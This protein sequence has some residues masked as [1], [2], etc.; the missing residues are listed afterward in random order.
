MVQGVG[1]RPFIHKLAKECEVSGRIQNTVSGVLIEA[2]GFQ[3]ALEVF[4]R[5]IRERAPKLSVIVS[6]EKEDIPI[7]PEE[8]EFYIEKSEAGE[9]NQTL[10]SPDI[11]ICED[12]RR[13]LLDPNDRRFGY[14]FLNCT[15][16]GPR[17]SIIR[18][19]P[20]DR[21][22][23]TMMDFEMCE[24]CR[25]EYEDIEDRRYH[26]QPNCCETCGPGLI[27]EDQ[28]GCTITEDVIAEAKKRILSGEILAIKGLG[29]F[30]LACLPERA[31]ELRKRKHRDEKPFALMCRNEEIVK[32]LAT[33]TP[34]EELVLNGFRKP[35]V[36]L[37]KKA[38]GPL[39]LHEISENEYVGVMLPYTPLHVLLMEPE[40]DC[41]IMTS[42]NVSDCPI[43]YRNEEAKE[44]LVN[45][46]DGFVMHDREIETRC[47]DSLVWV[48]DGQ[49]YFVRRSRGYAPFPIYQKRPMSPILALGAEQKASFAYAKDCRV[50]L[51]QHIGDLKNVETLLHY[52][53]QMAHFERLFDIK[54]EAVVCDLHPDYL[55]TEVANRM[56]Q[57]RR[58]PKISV[59]HHHAHMV[60][61][62]ADNDVEEVCIGIVWDGTGLGEPKEGAPGAAS[63]PIWGGE[64]LLG[65]ADHYERH[66]TIRPIGLVGG[67]V[68]TKEIWRIG[69]ALA[70]DADVEKRFEG[71]EAKQSILEKMLTTG[72]NVTYATS[73]GRLFDGIYTILS[74][75]NMVSY[76]GQGAV[77]LEASALKDCEERYS[78]EIIREEDIWVFDYREMVRSIVSECEQGEDPGRMAAKFMNTLVWMAVD[79]CDRIRHKTGVK[80]VVLSGGV[81]QNQY[82]LSKMKDK[83]LEQGFY[84]YTHKRVSTNDEGLSL[85][86]LMIAEKRLNHVSGGAF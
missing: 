47:D 58:I 50:F 25:A 32:Q 12:C 62:M 41:L 27:F 3:D 35:I 5:G 15:N 78:Y 30:H 21:G 23:T 9:G 8:A 6:V 73:M 29:G 46:A 81:F 67:D 36:L 10:I 51:S 79:L 86:Q 72:R 84:V 55:S 19:V 40:I 1:F 53:E 56:S 80:R 4:E 16:C 38:D 57:E 64:V 31:N 82:L 74:G 18:R 22:N 69:L 60:S 45:I 37:R 42:A 85:G 14:P 59:Q 48:V 44:A 33:I 17:F 39:W 7:I 52:E 13:E 43:V 34:E 24:D 49:E 2:Q 65:D 11:G 75:K 28:K 77:L 66:G 20:Y 54:P 63:A 83:L 70:K 71:M 76:E 61:C 68:A 26:A